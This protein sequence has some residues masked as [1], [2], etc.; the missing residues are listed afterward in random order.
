PF[1]DEMQER[2]HA[3]DQMQN[4]ISLDDDLRRGAGVRASQQ[5][6][7]PLGKKSRH[8]ADREEDRRSEPDRRVGHSQE[9]QKTNHARRLKNSRMSAKPGF[10]NN[11]PPGTG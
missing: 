6:D 1:G 4:K 5:A 10:A 7:H 2:D 8:D 9:S 11:P 3:T